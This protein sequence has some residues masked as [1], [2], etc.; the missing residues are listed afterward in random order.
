[1][2]QFVKNKSTNYL[3]FKQVCKELSI[4]YATGKNWLKLNKITFDKQADNELFFSEESVAKLKKE[5][6]NGSNSALKSRRNKTCVTGNSLYGSYVSE[7]S[8]NVSV[9]QDLL[10]KIG[11]S[12]L[13]ISDE[14]IELLLAECA[15]QLYA[16]RE[17]QNG[18]S[19]NLLFK[20]L[21]GELVLGSFGEFIDAFIRDKNAVL[22]FIEK[23]PELFSIK[24]IYEKNEDILGLLY[25]STKNIG[26][27]KATG[28]YYTP[29]R[30]VQ[31]LIK[32]L[33][34]TQKAINNKTFLD[35]CCGTG[36]FLL[37][38]PESVRLECV[39]GND[40][41][42]VSVKLTRINLA[43]KFRVYDYKL[44]SKHASESNYL[45]D[46]SK[47]VPDIII[48]NPPWGFKFSQED[49]I[50]LK[51]KYKS[52]QNKNIESFDV[53]IEESLKN[54]TE[55][56][57]LS[58]VLPES[59]LNVKSHKSIR[60]IISE[61]C[62]IEYLEFL[63]NSFDGVHCPAIILQLKRTNEKISTYGLVVK[64]LSTQFT[65]KTKRNLNPEIFSLNITDEEYELI[66][67]LFAT[68]NHATLKNN[69][70]FALGIVTGD[71]AKYIEDIKTSVNEPILKGSDIYKYKIK[72]SNNFINFISE[73]FQQVAPTEYYR[74]EEKLLYRFIC[75]QPVFAY[76]NQQMLSLNSCNILI[77]RIK[78]LEMKYIMAIFNSR[79]VQFLYAK[80][81][82]S[83]KI[84]RA[85]LEQIPIP[86]VDKTVQKEI[87]NIVNQLNCES[88]SQVLEHLYDKLEYKIFEIYNLTT[89][90]QS[91]ILNATKSK[92]S[93][94]Y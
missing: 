40:L 24:Y 70:D 25:L 13:V 35:P 71:N 17:I 61:S 43:L 23:Y 78:C 33:F 56:G 69:A 50:Y 3:T 34:D 16:Q 18:F 20:Y 39:Y 60:S 77:P 46:N 30:I 66:S 83:V 53:F 72:S 82:N 51:N 79:T 88:D 14:V 63:G 4:S 84:L 9:I 94:L 31:K 44:L 37:Q 45:T 85:H 7:C 38:L 6:L 92:N 54:L 57:I 80:Q 42:S 2:S 10:N 36:N 48:G 75:N 22:D 41:D 12:N 73:S 86:V 15:L 27:R 81:F 52:A 49:Q 11:R 64:N 21:I 68:E 55:N 67:K 91:I 62:N 47:V 28:S 19:S 29:T 26:N 74:S 76:D 32:N 5:I 8:Q 65:I 1:M 90:E 89:S 93:F 87:I 58:F 59:I